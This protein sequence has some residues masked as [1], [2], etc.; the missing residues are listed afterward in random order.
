MNKKDS[1]IRLRSKLKKNL[2]SIGSWIQIPDSSVAEIMG[3]S[4]YDW[5]AIDLEHGSI[6]ISQLPSI[7]RS[8]E[9]G[10]TLPFVRVAQGEVKDCKQALDAG[11][12]GIIVPMIKTAKQLE[13]IRKFCCWPPSGNRGVGFSR[14]NLY[15]RNFNSY[16]IEAQSPFFVAMI[17]HIEA[18]NDLDS[19]L[20]VHGLD[21]VI[22]GLYDLS[23]SMN[24]TAKFSDLNF[25]KTVNKIRDICLNKN[26]PCGSHIVHPSIDKLNES[27]NDGFRFIPYS[28]DSVFL[29]IACK[30]PK[31]ITDDE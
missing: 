12:A 21:A 7:C 8:L 19:I 6:S 14:A 23:A 4:G 5:V 2:Y 20:E 3:H 27:I 29:N 16:E 25:I 31:N 1:I 9:L 17:E 30:N 15:G 18:V 13:N 11:A 10:D 28:I 26:I 22:I 24:I